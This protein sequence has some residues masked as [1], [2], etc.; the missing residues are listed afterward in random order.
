MKDVESE[1]EGRLTKSNA[2]HYPLVTTVNVRLKTMV[3][4]QKKDMEKHAIPTEEDLLKFN[5]DLRIANLL[6][7]TREE[8]TENEEA[9]KDRQGTGTERFE[10]RR[11]VEDEEDNAA[12]LIV[13][14]PVCCRRS[15]SP[16][17]A[18]VLVL[19]AAVAF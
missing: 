14:L 8:E 11:D 18:Q 12:R 16:R 4:K 10:I 13:R 9:P 15:F 19:V 7:G 6:E 5:E 3:K 1:M 2:A 17:R